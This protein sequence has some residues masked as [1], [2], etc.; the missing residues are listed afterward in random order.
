MKCKSCSTEMVLLSSASYCP[1]GCGIVF[2]GE[3]ESCG[4]LY[5]VRGILLH[6][7]IVRGILLHQDP[8]KDLG[9]KK[10]SALIFRSLAALCKHFADYPTALVYEVETDINIP[11]NVDVYQNNELAEVL[12]KKYVGTVRE[13]TKE[14]MHK[15]K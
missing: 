13:H 1:G 9:K 10:K 3:T 7:Y 2:E 6:Q 5:I 12:V 4:K 11:L 15:D 14:L 8:K